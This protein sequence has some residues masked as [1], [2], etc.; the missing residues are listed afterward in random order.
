[1]SP[2]FILCPGCD[3]EHALKPSI[4]RQEIHCLRCGWSNLAIIFAD[5]LGLRVRLLPLI[6]ASRE[7]PPIDPSASALDGVSGRDWVG[8]L[9]SHALLESIEALGATKGNIQL[10]DREAGGL[11]IRSQMGFGE[12]FLAKF[13]VVTTGDD[14]AC[15][16]ALRSGQQIIC[17]NVF[18]DDRFQGL[19]RIFLQEGLAA[20]ISTPLIGGKGE[21]VGMLSDHFSRPHLPS[22]Y[23]L[24]LLEHPLKRVER[25][26]HHIP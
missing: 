25:T 21:V 16:H 22:R 23:A 3:R 2:L 1:M 19:R 9:L 18:T 4:G 10:Y 7:L 14:C 5:S 15:S 17:R 24:S 8:D 13:R 11:V 26:L 6:E 20:V 12:D